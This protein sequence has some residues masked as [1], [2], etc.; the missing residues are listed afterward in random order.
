MRTVISGIVLA[1]GSSTRMGR[2]KM[3][4]RLGE[5]PVLSYVMASFLASRLDEVVVVAS[6]EVA[7]SLSLSRPPRVRVFVNSDAALGMSS[8]LKLGLAKVRGKAAVVGLGD[9]PLLLPSTIDEIVAAYEN[10]AALIVVPVCQGRRGNP[11]LLDRALF[12]EVMK[13][14]GDKGARSVIAANQESVKE[15]TV[16]DE[17]VL[18]DVDTESDLRKAELLLEGRTKRRRSPAEGRRRRLPQTGERSSPRGP[19]RMRSTS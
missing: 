1:A 10:S 2:P 9:Q 19:P 3:L 11:V 8:S 5:R 6:R 15:V 14:Q 13:I 4:A 18:L 12:P 16:S 17:G 7:E